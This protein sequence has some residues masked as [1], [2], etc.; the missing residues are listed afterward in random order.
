MAVVVV[1][2]VDLLGSLRTTAVPSTGDC[3]VVGISG[4]DRVAVVVIRGGLLWLLLLLLL[5]TQVV[6]V[7]IAV[8]VAVGRAG[9]R[10]VVILVIGVA[11]GPAA[12]AAP[13]AAGAGHIL[14]EMSD[15]CA[16]SWVMGVVQNCRAQLIVRVRRLLLLL[17][18]RLDWVICCRCWIQM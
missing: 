18:L 10:V 9:A 14:V 3:T 6:I 8:A 5:I 1:T 11:V 15:L 13:A 2:G 16:S 12:E 7:A 4:A 17:L